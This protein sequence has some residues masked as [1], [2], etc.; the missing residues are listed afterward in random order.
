M[1]KFLLIAGTSL[2]ILT[3][4]GAIT[5]HFLLKMYIESDEFRE[6]VAR[7]LTRASHGIVSKSIVDVSSLNVVGL[8]S[9][10][11][12]AINIRSADKAEHVVSISSAKLTPKLV[13][14]LIPGPVLFNAELN[15]QSKGQVKMSG[16]VPLSLLSKSNTDESD[17]EVRGEVSG[18]SA[19]ELVDLMQTAQGDPY[20]RLAEG[21]L[22]G[23]FLYT[24]PLGKA[25]TKGEKNGHLNLTLTAAKWTIPSEKKVVP[26]ETLPIELKLKDFEVNLEKPIVL[27]DESGTATLSG[28]INLPK[29]AGQEKSWDIRANVAGSA[30]LLLVVTKL[31]KCPS[32]PAAYTFSVTGDFSNARCLGL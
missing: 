12:G 15:M 2:L 3:V 29:L 25:V 24:K 20:F 13:S 9:V 27:K 5:S 18:I 32:P 11:S 6:Q 21:T 19:V 16:R 22:N 17:V 23:T 10:E 7:T 31:F 4:V 30:G 28:A 1:K 14:L 8:M 26:I